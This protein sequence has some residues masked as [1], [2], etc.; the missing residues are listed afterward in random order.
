M[1]IILRITESRFNAQGKRAV[2]YCYFTGLFA[3]ASTPWPVSV[4]WQYLSGDRNT[5]GPSGANIKTKISS[6]LIFEP[7]LSSDEQTYGC[8]ATSNCIGS[9]DCPKTLGI[10]CRVFL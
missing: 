5:Q 6:S 9:T 2:L 3:Q 7:V 4:T 10:I 1:S 8:T